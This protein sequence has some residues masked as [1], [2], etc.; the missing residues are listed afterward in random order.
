MTPDEIRACP[1]R[2]R[3]PLL[4]RAEDYLAGQRH[5]LT[6]VHTR[7]FGDAGIRLTNSSGHRRRMG[8]TSPPPRLPTSINQR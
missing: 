4:L 5:P 1:E 7:P 2:H 8:R 6:L 3:S